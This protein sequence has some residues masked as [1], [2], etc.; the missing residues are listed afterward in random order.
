MA[1]V[2]HQ[3]ECARQAITRAKT[4]SPGG[5]M[6]VPMAIGIEEGI[7]GVTIVGVGEESIV[8]KIGRRRGI[9]IESDTRILSRRNLERM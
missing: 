7:V 6:E 8:R 5:T 3:L 4:G 2:N 9:M 1:E